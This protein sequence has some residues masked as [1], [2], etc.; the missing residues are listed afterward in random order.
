MA[1]CN[2]ALKL[3]RRRWRTGFHLHFKNCSA[4]GNTTFIQFP[5]CHV[6]NVQGIINFITQ[7]WYF[8]AFQCSIIGTLLEHYNVCLHVGFC[9]NVHHC[10]LTFCKLQISAH[11][12]L[13]FFFLIH[14]SVVKADI[15][16]LNY[17]YSLEIKWYICCWWEFTIYQGWHM[18]NCCND[19]GNSVP[20]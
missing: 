5:V 8:L 2:P 17:N 16:H 11:W 18:C 1:Y 12:R 10:V 15:P 20:I 19:E 14:V 3:N 7:M 9:E 6:W 13:R 4:W